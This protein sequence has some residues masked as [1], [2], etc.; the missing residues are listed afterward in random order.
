MAPARGAP[1]APSAGLADGQMIPFPPGPLPAADPGA[2]SVTPAEAP[3]L[4]ATP[5]APAEW[6][7]PVPA[8]AGAGRPLLAV[9]LPVTHPAWA[10]AVA[11][12]VH[13]LLGRGVARADLVLTPAHLGRLEITLEVTGDQTTAHF[14]TATPAARDL[15]EQA[16]PRLREVLQQAGLQLGQA[17]VNTS[18]HQ[19]R[20]DRE[21]PPGWAPPRAP[22]PPPVAAGHAPPP[23]RARGGVD[24]FA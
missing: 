1:P 8:A 18:A 24:T 23:A 15:L 9:P 20:H 2:A 11:G 3:P 13:G 7:P 6:T 21:A 16:L 10:D 17:E 12:Q 4:P 19:Q 5:A 22:T 14:L